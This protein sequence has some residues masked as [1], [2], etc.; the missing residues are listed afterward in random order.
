MTKPID[1]IKWTELVDGAIVI[2]KGNASAYKTGSWRSSRPIV[3]KK[4]CIKC[5]VCW[6]F[7]PEGC[8][9][10]D[11]EGYYLPDLDYCKGCGICVK[12]CTVGCI[13]MIDEEE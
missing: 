5:A 1:Q 8:I 3:N 6:I 11:A 2:E 13:T 10:Q 9:H 7:C 12:E 4:E